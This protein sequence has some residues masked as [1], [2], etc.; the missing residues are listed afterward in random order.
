[1]V[2][3]GLSTNANNR[4]GF[5]VC[6]AAGRVAYT[7]DA[8]GEVMKLGYDALGRVV[9]QT[10][11]VTLDP[12]SAAPSQATMDAWATANAASGD[13]VSRMLYD[14]AGHLIYTV[15]AEGFVTEFRS[16]A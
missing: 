11:F 9:K 10:H 7:I 2:S 15:D 8:A 5:S 16:H 6:D 14:L 13:R 1:M 3:P 4:P 12:V